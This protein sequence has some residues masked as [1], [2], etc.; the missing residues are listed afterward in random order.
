[1]KLLLTNKIT[2]RNLQSI[3]D[4]TLAG[5]YLVLFECPISFDLKGMLLGRPI[6]TCFKYD[7]E[8]YPNTIIHVFQK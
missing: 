3:H 2:L 4:C 8:T 1:M 6:L 5:D 7:S